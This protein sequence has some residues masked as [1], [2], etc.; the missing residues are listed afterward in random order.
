MRERVVCGGWVRDDEV[1]KKI[2]RLS[3]VGMQGRWLALVP[4]VV[5]G[6]LAVTGAQAQN[7]PD[8]K[9]CDTITKELAMRPPAFGDKSRA[10]YDLQSYQ[11]FCN[12]PPWAGM[13]T[14]NDLAALKPLVCTHGGIVDYVNKSLGCW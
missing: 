10:S 3:E 1:E 2:V 8:R 9:D 6:L 4:A 11:A 5:A 14:A 7:Y 12:M 13:I